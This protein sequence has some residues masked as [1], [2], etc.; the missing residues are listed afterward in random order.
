MNMD[1]EDQT[2]APGAE[3]EGPE[4]AA[5][6][7]GTARARRILITRAPETG[8]SATKIAALVLIVAGIVGLAYGGFTYTND[9][10]EIQ[11]GSMSL[12]IDQHRTVPIPLWAGIAATLLGTG[13]LLVPARRG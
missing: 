2:A 12:T 6:E 1:Q 10:Q 5:T 9:R 8:M 7:S 11:M 4:G 3:G 13:L